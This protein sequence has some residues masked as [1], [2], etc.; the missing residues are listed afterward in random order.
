MMRGIPVL[1][2]VAVLSLPT[3]VSAGGFSRGT[4]NTDILFEDGTANFDASA[5]FV[6]P[7]RK[8]D[9]NPVAALSGTEYTDSYVIPSIAAKYSFNDYL[10]CA[11]TYTNPFGGDSINEVMSNRGK[12][13]EKFITHE[14]GATCAA[15]VPLTTGRIGLIAGVFYEEFDYDFSGFTR[16]GP[17]ITPIDFSLNSNDIGWRA[18]VAYEIPEI[19]FRTQLMYRSGTEHEDKSGDAYLPAFGISPPLT[20]AGE[21]PQS[22]ELKVQSGIAPGWLAFGSIK[23]TDWSVLD[24]LDITLGGA[25]FNNQYY[26]RDGITVT[27]GIGHEFTDSVTGAVAFTYD[28]GVST[29]WDLYGDTYTTAITA[30]VKD[31][32]GGKLSAAVALAYQEGAEENK[33]APGMNSSSQNTWGTAV[34][35]RYNLKF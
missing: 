2:V 23:W 10:S 11:A 32:W 19:A 25:S 31:N 3:F 35:V 13:E 26:W 21:L 30:S 34:Q 24:T 4:A 12:V 1:A 17:G 18:G 20:G 33:F 16:A 29:G 8:Y 6:N 15:F 28:R 7:N 22:V 14:Y 9:R 5:T 27:G